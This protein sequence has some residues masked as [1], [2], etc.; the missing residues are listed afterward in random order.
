MRVRMARVTCDA[1]TS[2]CGLRFIVGYSIVITY[3]SARREK[4]FHIGDSD[5][6]D[7]SAQASAAFMAERPGSGSGATAMAL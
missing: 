4:D 2:H 7:S 5:L 6:A 1:R 3:E